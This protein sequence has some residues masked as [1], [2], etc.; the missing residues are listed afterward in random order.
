M[1]IRACNRIPP[2]P[3]CSG[4][5]TPR[6]HGPAAVIIPPFDDELTHSAERAGSALLE[7]L[8][9]LRGDDE[10]DHLREPWPVGHPGIVTDQPDRVFPRLLD[11]LTV[12][13]QRELLERRGPSGLGGAQDVALPAKL[14]I[15]LG[16]PEA[17]V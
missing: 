2:I 15:R 3:E 17:V 11:H 12:P 9:V 14:E 10:R 7:I 1:T 16:Q 6:Q 8:L 4:F 13:L 5:T